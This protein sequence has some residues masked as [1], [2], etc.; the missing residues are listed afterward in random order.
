M[1]SQHL[2]LLILM[3]LHK[4]FNFGL[5]FGYEVATLVLEQVNLIFKLLN[6]SLEL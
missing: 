5:K 4:L 6:L 3:R 1:S 2:L